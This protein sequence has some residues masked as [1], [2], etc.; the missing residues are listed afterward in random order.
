MVCTSGLHKVQSSP[1]IL[2]P[3]Q[4]FS[5]FI[6]IFFLGRAHSNSKMYMILVIDSRFHIISDKVF[7]RDTDIA[8]AFL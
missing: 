6:W 3:E 4:G 7:Y 2:S 5:F 8:T 1:Q